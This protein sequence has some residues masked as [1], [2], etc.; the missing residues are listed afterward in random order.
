MGP[1]LHCGRTQGWDPVRRDNSSRGLEPRPVS[2]RDRTPLR[3]PDPARSC[4]DSARLDTDSWLPMRR[5]A[6]CLIND[7]SSFAR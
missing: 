5:L 2:A 6:P 3:L 7:M 1:E 4:L